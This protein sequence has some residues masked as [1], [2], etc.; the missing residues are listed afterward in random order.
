MMKFFYANSKE[1]FEAALDS[2]RIDDDAIVFITDTK[3][4]WTHGLMWGGSP[5]KDDVQSMIDE[6]I[7]QV[8]NQE[9]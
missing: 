5:T 4:I 2:G 3:E 1:D 6:S 9:I 8:L 7:T